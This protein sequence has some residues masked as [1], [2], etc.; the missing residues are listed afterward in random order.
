MTATFGL[1][2]IT[3]FALFSKKENDGK[4]PKT[5]SWTYKLWQKLDKPYNWGI[6]I[7]VTAVL[8]L[9]SAMHFSNTWWQQALV[10]LSVIGLMGVGNFPSV[11]KIQTGVHKRFAQ[12][13]SISAVLWLITKGWWAMLALPIPFIIYYFM[14][15]KY[16]DAE[17]TFAEWAGFSSAFI[18][19][20]ILALQNL[21]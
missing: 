13:T 9:I 21:I 6:Y 7:M 15:K 3:W 20:I 4:W 12:L 10:L 19:V 17:G 8:F 5:Y 11:N 2:F 18:A 16:P 14:G 1:G